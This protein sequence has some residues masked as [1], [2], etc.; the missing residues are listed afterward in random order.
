LTMNNEL[1]IEEINLLC[2]EIADT[3][4]V[5]RM[6]E[7]ADELDMEMLLANPRFYGPDFD[8]CD[9]PWYWEMK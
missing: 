6:N 4:S 2:R 9:G 7:Y 1:S 3:I 8:D 5:E